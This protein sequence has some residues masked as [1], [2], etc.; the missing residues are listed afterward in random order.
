MKAS[1]KTIVD[2]ILTDASPAQS[3]RRKWVLT[4]EAFDKLLDFLAEDRESAGERYLEIRSTLVRFF[5]WRGCPSPE[6]HAD[7]TINRIAKRVSECEE[8]RTPSS[9]Y[10]GV[11]RL[12]LPEVKKRPAKQP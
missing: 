4:L 1:A 9:Y 3:P 2:S 12:V 10:L 5:Q 8:I 7:E 6:D 11:A